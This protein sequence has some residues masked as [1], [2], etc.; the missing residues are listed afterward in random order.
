LARDAAMI[1]FPNEEETPPVTKMY[2]AIYGQFVCYQ[3]N[4]GMGKYT[5]AQNSCSAIN[6]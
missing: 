1:P 5:F 4:K 6:L 3:K 2:F